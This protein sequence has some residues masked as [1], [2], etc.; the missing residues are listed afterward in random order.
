MFRPVSAG[1]TRRTAVV[2][3]TL[4]LLLSASAAMPA[5]AAQPVDR[6]PTAPSTNSVSSGRGTHTP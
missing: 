3:A 4:A 1:R 5:S 6:S 2:A